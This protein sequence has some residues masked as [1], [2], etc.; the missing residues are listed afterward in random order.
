VL[1]G[2]ELGSLL[3]TVKG[4]PTDG[5]SETPDISLGDDVTTWMYDERERSLGITEPLQIYPILETA[6]AWAQGRTLAAH[7]EDVSRLWAGFSAVAADNPYAADRHRYSAV[8][9]GTAGPANRYVGYPYTK[10]MNSNQFVD[11][12]ASFVLCSAAVARRLGIPRDRW[13]FPWATAEAHSPFVSVR[14]FLHLAP[15]LSRAGQ[16]V[17]A[18]TGRPAA[19]ASLVDLYACFPAAVELQAAALGIPAGRPQTLTG[20]MRF[21]GGPWN[22][23]GL[24]ML[25]NVV[26]GLREKPDTYALCSTNGGFATRFVVGA[27]S[28][29]PHPKGFQQAPAPFA[30]EPDDVRPV[31]LSHSGDMAVEAFSVVHDKTNQPVE[32]L[33]ACRNQDGVRAWAKFHDPADLQGLLAMQSPGRPVRFT[34]GKAVLA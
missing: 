7:M 22:S 1:A 12:A 30:A 21:A 26:A 2:A 13:V 24:H 27:Y 11:Q 4:V 25:A 8:E 15:Q 34:Q 3:R 28:G 32:G 5:A 18:L 10:Q 23:Y 14:K 31:D 6:I 29:T 20:G 19:D 9:I 16:A 33:V 17:A